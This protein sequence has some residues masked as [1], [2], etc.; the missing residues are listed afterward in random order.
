M[1]P[2]PKLLAAVGSL[3]VTLASPARGADDT[4]LPIRKVV[5]YKHGLGYF[6]RGGKVSGEGV[7]SLRFSSSQMNDVLKSLTALDLGGGRVSSI[8]YDS[9]APVSRLLS[10]FGFELPQD[11]ALVAMIQRFRGAEV[12]IELAGGKQTGSLAGV[13]MR[14]VPAGNSSIQVPRVSLLIDEGRVVSFDT[15][16]IQALRFLDADLRQDVHRYLDILRDSY[17]AERKSLQLRLEGQGER[18]IFVAYT[19]EVPVWKASYRLVLGAKNLLQGW[20]IVDNTSD[21]DWSGVDLSLVSGLPVSF[22]EDLYTPHYSRRPVIKVSEELAVAPQTH[23]GGWEKRDKL[24][25]NK[26]GAPAGPATPGPGAPTAARGLARRAGEAK[27]AAAAPAEFEGSGALRDARKGLTREEAL[28]EAVGA[29]ST[30]TRELGDLFEYR[31]DHKVT[32]ARNRSALIPIVGASVEAAHVSI[33]NAAIRAKNP[34][35]A[36]RFKNTSGLTLEGGPVTVLDGEAYAGEALIETLKPDEQRYLSYAVDLAVTIDPKSDP[37]SGRVERVRIVDGVFWL[38]S[39]L[40]TKTRYEIRNADA[41]ERALVIEHARRAGF[42][43]VSP[44]K[45]LEETPDHWRFDAPVGAAQAT[46]FEVTEESD[47]AQQVALTNVGNDEIELYVRNKYLS[48]DMEKALRD[49]VARKGELADLERR[50]AAANQEL[51]RLAEDQERLRKNLGALGSTTAEQQLRARYV[52]QLQ[53]SE[54]RIAE[55]NPGRQKLI[56]ERDG[57]RAALDQRMREL[58]FDNKL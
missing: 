43:L 39:K 31:I 28:D 17:R 13:E 5:L 25:E 46:T 3:L 15:S 48:A 30:S 14:A 9:Q 45:P 42:R 37:A 29:S 18:E 40:V 6:E 16:E 4:P 7:A 41:K 11:G 54:D 49:L 24:A 27:D 20:A 26:P 8:G 22:I 23:E 2:S 56:E 12:E 33:F 21:E 53:K 52:G 36:I 47:S 57:K 44:A 34:L 32:V 35:S 58:A 38:D 51:A 10:E 55:L 1:R 50:I 19:V